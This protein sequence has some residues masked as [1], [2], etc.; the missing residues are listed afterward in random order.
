MFWG[1]K[2]GVE[3]SYN[4]RKLS[5]YDISRFHEDSIPGY[6]ISNTGRDW[7]HIRSK[8]LLVTVEDHWTTIQVYRDEQDSKEDPEYNTRGLKVW[9]S[10]M[11]WAHRGPWCEEAQNLWDK[12]RQLVH[13]RE[14]KNIAF[15][16]KLH[17]K[18]LEEVEEARQYFI[19]ATK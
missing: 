8:L 10:Y 9:D 4:L 14:Q 7:L 19:E 1:K 18:R 17:K 15:H 6:T 12:I 5:F 2:K 13:E 16:E 3:R 11:G